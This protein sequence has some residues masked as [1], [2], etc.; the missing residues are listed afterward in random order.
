MSSHHLTAISL[1]ALLAA[2]AV[3]CKKEELP[4]QQTGADI[5][6]M[7][8]DIFQQPVPASAQQL[9]TTGT[10]ATVNG[11]EISAQD[12]QKELASA[13]NRFRQQIPP[14]QI[15]QIMPRIQ[16]Q[17]LDQMI[18]RQLLIQE[19]DR[20]NMTI[21]D[22][23]IEE[24]RTKLEASL[25][26]GLS[27]GAVLEQRGITEEQ[28]HKEFGDEVR[29]TR[30]IEQVTSN[31]THVTDADVDEFYKENVERFKEPETVTARHILIAVTNEE[32]KAAQ[33]E[34]AEAIRA[35]LIG[36]EDFAEVAVAESDDPGSK[37]TGGEYTFPRGRMVPPFEEAAFTQEIGEIGPLVE[38]QF[39]YHIIQ[40]EKREPARDVPL[41]EVRTNVA[42]Y[43]R[44]QKGPAALQE[45]L[46]GLRSN[47]EVNI[48]TVK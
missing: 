41:E 11:V 24:A 4:T 16:E 15:A 47:A 42:A 12:F 43:L 8:S 19:A 36:G 21:T 17:V 31:A 14:E 46:A 29:I 30:L 3:G 37:S 7:N 38:T 22:E 44:S 18:A 10:I 2:V 13:M 27:L 32:D 1:A 28:F 48:S 23:D 40:V 45:Y 6:A 9:P 34:K 26:P 35:R 39:G 20:L 25:P 33:K 5:P